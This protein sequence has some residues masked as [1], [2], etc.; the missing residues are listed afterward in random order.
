MT[1]LQKFTKRLV[2]CRGQ[3]Y[4]DECV[5]CGLSV[6]FAKQCRKYL[7]ATDEACCLV[8]LG[9]PKMVIRAGRV[10]RY[11]AIERILQ[12]WV[13]SGK[14]RLDAIARIEAFAA[15]PD[16]S[17]CY[18]NAYREARDSGWTD[19]TWWHFAPEPPLI[20]RLTGERIR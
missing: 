10:G 1:E 3:A 2:A 17:P 6:S 19:K 8:D 11:V 20:D 18:W 12:A 4:I 14:D 13:L 7:L 9:I 5:R 15:S 16:Y